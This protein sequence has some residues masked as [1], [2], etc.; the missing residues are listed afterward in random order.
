MDVATFPAPVISHAVAP[1]H[2]SSRADPRL[3]RR[4]I[5]EGWK[6]PIGSRGK[7]A[8]GGLGTQSPGRRSKGQVPQKLVIFFKS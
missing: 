1:R 2:M 4:F 6:S 7:A 5:R 3:G 8:V